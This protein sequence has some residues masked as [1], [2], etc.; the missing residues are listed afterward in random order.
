MAH[1]PQLIDGIGTTYNPNKQSGTG[2]I[3]NIALLLKILWV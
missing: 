2:Q 1:Q 3:L